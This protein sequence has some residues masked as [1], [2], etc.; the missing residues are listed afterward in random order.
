MTKS[1][2]A[3][4]V[5][6]EI[7]RGN[8]SMD[9]LI[10]I[11]QNASRIA[12]DPNMQGAPLAIPAGGQHTVDSLL[13]ILM[14]P[15]S[16]GAAVAFAEHISGSEA[17]FAERMNESM[18]NLGGWSEFRNAHGA[19]PHETNAFSLALLARAFIERYPDILR[20]TSA[21]SYDFLGVRR[22]NT[23]LLYTSFPYQDADGFKTGTTTEAGHCFTGT[24]YRN[25]RRVI[26]V[27]MGGVDNNQRYT[28][29]RRML[30]WGF[31]E[32]ARREAIRAATPISVIVN[33]QLIYTEESLEVAWD[34][35]TLPMRE[36]F[37]A[38]GY[39]VFWNQELQMITAV[40]ATDG[41]AM[42]IQ[43]GNGTVRHNN[44]N[45]ELDVAA[46]MQNGRTFIPITLVTEGL[47]GELEIDNINRTLTIVLPVSA[48]E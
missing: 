38:F 33:E 16:N 17:A 18:A 25:G 24:A 29:T 30:D 2:T 11:S 48:G 1:M 15:S 19:L 6:E 12:G 10:T 28:E 47:G 20:I 34:D 27:V 7:E 4:V 8:L 31:E 41:D 46:H 22:N 40:R 35:L 45:L 23:N 42:M 3:F 13:H 5:Y 37:E 43:I 9:T 32:I 26:T 39:S 44:L 36:I 21:R 14:L